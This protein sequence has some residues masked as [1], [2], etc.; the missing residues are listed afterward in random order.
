MKIQIDTT[1]KRIRLDEEVNL[2]EFFDFMD[3]ILPNGEW[4]EFT[5]DYT[6]IKNWINPINVPYTYTP[7]IPPT[8]PYN[9]PPI[10]YPFDNI[11][12]C[13]GTTEDGLKDGVFNIRTTT[14]QITN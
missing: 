4:K 9:P 8:Q 1:N 12:Y 6:I 14:S 7:Y 11:I 3:K 5:L 2:S 13:N 10:T